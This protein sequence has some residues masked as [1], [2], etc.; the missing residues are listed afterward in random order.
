MTPL[1]QF[2]WLLLPVAAFHL[3]LF[4]CHPERYERE[5]ERRDRNIKVGANAIATVAKF[6][7]S[8]R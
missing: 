5:R 1:Q 7:L 2:G 6:F 8:R 3:W 4:I